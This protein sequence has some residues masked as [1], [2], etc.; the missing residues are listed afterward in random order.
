MP[1][2]TAWL[3]RDAWAHTQIQLAARAAAPATGRDAWRQELRVQ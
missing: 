1:H 2:R 3:T